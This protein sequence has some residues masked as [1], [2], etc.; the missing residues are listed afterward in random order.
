[1]ICLQYSNKGWWGVRAVPVGIQPQGTFCYGC[2][3]LDKDLKRIYYILQWFFSIFLACNTSLLPVLNKFLIFFFYSIWFH[4]FNFK[5]T[6]LLHLSSH[7]FS[8][9]IPLH[10]QCK[11]VQF[12]YNYTEV[13][14]LQR[15]Y[16][17]V[18]SVCVWV[19][20][21]GWGGVVT[22]VLRKFWALGTYP[23][24]VCWGVCKVQ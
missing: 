22:K 10:H 5:L 14:G 21:W 19:G 17:C 23:D 20:G 6:K 15:R 3:G 4:L 2:F 11:H 9:Y 16:T 1:M 24:L 7:W 12:Q 18:Y 8:R 13:G